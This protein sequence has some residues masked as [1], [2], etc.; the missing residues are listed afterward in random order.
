MISPWVA[1]R[2]FSAT[3]AVCLIAALALSGCGRKGGLD[4]PPGASIVN[5]PVPAQPGAEVTPD[6]QPT[7][8]AQPAPPRSRTFL[9]WLID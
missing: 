5:Q 8:I 1:T 9:D 7:Q 3:V 4:A 6:G 2:R